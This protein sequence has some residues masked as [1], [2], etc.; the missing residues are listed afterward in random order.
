MIW[1]G[2]AI[3]DIL[4]RRLGE[5]VRVTTSFI[6]TRYCCGHFVGTKITEIFPG[7]FW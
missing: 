1:A 4:D 5:K 2:G 7:V 3:E 6:D